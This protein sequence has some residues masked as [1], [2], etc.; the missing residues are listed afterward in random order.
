MCTDIIAL[1]AIVVFG[2]RRRVWHD[3]DSA[4]EPVMI[5]RLTKLENLVFP[6]GKVL[7]AKSLVNFTGEGLGSR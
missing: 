5:K 1:I 6:P 7:K 4:E 3:E 2:S